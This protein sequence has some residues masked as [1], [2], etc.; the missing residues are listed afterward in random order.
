MPGTFYFCIESGMQASPQEDGGLGEMP[1]FENNPSTELT[2][3]D[4]QI[5]ALLDSRSFIT[6]DSTDSALQYT[7]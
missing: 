4:C 2:A 1:S 6:K 5:V 3:G 7:E